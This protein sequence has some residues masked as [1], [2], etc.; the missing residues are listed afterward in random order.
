MQIDVFNGDAD[1]ICALIQLRLTNPCESMLLTGT[2]RDIQLLEQLSVTNNDQV[3]VLDISLDKNRHDLDRILQQ[4]AK[5]FYVDHHQAGVIPSHPN[6][7]T[8]INTDTNICTS[9]LVN[10]FLHG[11]YSAWAVTAAFGDNLIRSAEHAALSLSLSETELKLLKDL[12][13]CINYNSYGNTISDLHF[14]PDELYRELASYSSPFEFITDN[15]HI[16]QI[17]KA[18]YANDMAHAFQIEAEYSTAAIGVYILPDEAWARRVSGVFGNALANQNPARAHAIVSYNTQGD[19]QISVRSPLIKKTGADELCSTF[20]T[21]GGRKSA[22]GIN[23]LPADQ[24]PAFIAAFE[25]K[26][27]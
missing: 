3:T 13:T 24:L 14:S 21:G 25:E 26:Y 5:V 1:G 27:N 18:G 23:H 12:G 11:Q 9:L 7:T 20:P 22:A 16:Y 4:G 10:E 6:L 19:F 2:K 8:L 15:Q 17:L